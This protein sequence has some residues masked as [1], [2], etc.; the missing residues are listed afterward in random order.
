MAVWA[1]H[2][3]LHTLGALY[4]VAVCLLGLLLPRGLPYGIGGFLV[5]PLVLPGLLVVATAYY[6]TG[7]YL[8]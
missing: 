6:A 1:R 2:R 4:L 7:H 8:S 3:W 5:M